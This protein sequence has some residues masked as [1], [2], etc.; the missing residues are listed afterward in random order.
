VGIKILYYLCIPNRVKITI[1]IDFLKEMAVIKDIIIDRDAL[2]RVVFAMI[3][4]ADLVRKD[5]ISRGIYAKQSIE[6]LFYVSTIVNLK[7]TIVNNF[8]IQQI[9]NL[10]SKI[11]NRKS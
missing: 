9:V 11:V 7:S 3:Q 8:S 1:K 10:K 6:T 5:A 4:C 2:F